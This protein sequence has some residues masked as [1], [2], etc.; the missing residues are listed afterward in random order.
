[1]RAFSVASFHFPARLE[2]GAALKP[3]QSLGQRLVP[4]APVAHWQVS[5]GCKALPQPLHIVC[6]RTLTKW[7]GNSDPS[8]IIRD[9]PVALGCLQCAEPGI[10]LVG[11]GSVEMAERP[12]LAR[13]WRFTWRPRANSDVCRGENTT[14]CEPSTGAAQSEPV[15]RLK[16]A[17]V[18]GTSV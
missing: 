13:S 16:S 15:D 17:G 8:T 11:V 18:L 10:P 1:M 4:L 9:P 14:A 3:F 12:S 6:R 2:P 5:L 7:F